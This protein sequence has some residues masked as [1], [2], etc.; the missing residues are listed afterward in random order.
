MGTGL[1][2]FGGRRQHTHVSI[3]FLFDLRVFLLPESIV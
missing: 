3:S 1:F 2:S